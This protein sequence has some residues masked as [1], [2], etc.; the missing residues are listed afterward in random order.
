MTKEKQN[1][2]A[3]VENNALAVTGFEEFAGAGL[4]TVT[5]QDINIP[6]IQ[7]LQS[8]SPQVKKG[9]EKRI[10]NAEEGDIVASGINRLYKVDD[11]GNSTL[12]VSVVQK[13]T[14]LTEWAPNR[15]GLVGYHSLAEKD[16]LGI[17]KTKNPDG[18]EILVLPNANEIQE[19][20]YLFCVGIPSD[21]NETPF[22]CIMSMAQTKRSAVRQLYT[23]LMFDCQNALPTFAFVYTVGTAVKSKDEWSWVVPKFTKV[24]SDCGV[25]FVD[26]RG[27]LNRADTQGAQIFESCTAFL[28]TLKT[29]GL[30]NF[31]TRNNFSEYEEIENPSNVASEM[32]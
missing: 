14:L 26:S 18:K 15:G 13:I 23:Q 5:A 25:T 6:Y 3:K 30:E 4:E 32:I 28:K 2:V 24:T 1:E 16:S 19:T 22:F 21:K 11:T 20:D 9:S 7:F 29:I 17:K 8:S 12:N 27:I 10:P 31:L